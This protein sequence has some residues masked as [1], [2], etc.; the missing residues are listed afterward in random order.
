[1]D[2]VSR[3][4]SGYFQR[5]GVRPHPRLPTVP[6]PHI[7]GELLFGR[8]RISVSFM[9]DTGADFTIVAPSVAAYVLQG[10]PDHPP[11]TNSDRVDICGVGRGAVR[12]RIRSLGLSL[13]DD[14]N[15]SYWSTFSV[16][17]VDP[18]DATS[19]SVAWNLPSLLGRDVLRRFDLNLSYEPPSVSLTLSQ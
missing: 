18:G 10:E 14:S 1:M 9:I 15:Q 4:F 13:V 11:I 8:Q 3:V 16:L 2:S 7:R 6:K 5:W 19:K 12:T 17:L